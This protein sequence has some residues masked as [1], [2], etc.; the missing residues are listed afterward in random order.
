MKFVGIDWATDLH[1]VALEDEQGVVLDE[2]QIEHRPSGFAALLGRLAEE[3]GPSGVLVGLESGATLLLSAIVGA[4]YA[5]Y[6]LNP[7]QADRFRDRHSPAGAKDDRLDARVLADAVRTDRGRLRAFEPDSP[8][9]QEIALRDRERT[10]L[11]QIRAGMENQ[12]RQALSEYFPALADLRREMND[13]FLLGLL[14]LVRDPVRAKDVR[15]SSLERLIAEHRIRSLTAMEVRGRLREP[16]FALPDFLL[17]ARRDGALRLARIIGGFNEQIAEAEDALDDLAKKH[18][19][20]ELLKCLP[21]LGDRLAVRVVAELGDSR[22]RRADPSTLR[23][24]AGTAPV[25]RRSGKRGRKGKALV[26]MR[27]G[28]NRVLQS[29]L[30]AMAR[31]SVATS[32]WAKAY[33]QH[34]R[35]RGV[36]NATA[37]RSLSNKWAAIL[38]AVLDSRVPYDEARHAADLARYGVPWLKGTEAAA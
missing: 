13:P 12:L 21:G 9:A 16:S 3:G 27:R 7:K 33:L 30:Y 18:P 23:A 24:Y 14:E 2:W 35:A 26:L 19:D 36:P 1:D 37:I 34:C 25:T 28:C 32:A 31:A 17:A 4:G 29:A 22:A 6:V 10:R 38:W 8:L 11:V 15:L 5:A 20:Y